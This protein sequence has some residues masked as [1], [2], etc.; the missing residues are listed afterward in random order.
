MDPKEQQ[1]RNT[2]V[3]SSK[4][5][6]NSLKDEELQRQL[7]SYVC[8]HPAPGAA[9]GRGCQAEWGVATRTAV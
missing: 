8:H 4:N 2:Y 7:L 6:N 5:T 9:A 3:S 1:Q